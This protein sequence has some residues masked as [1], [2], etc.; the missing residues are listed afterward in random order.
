M[1]DQDQLITWRGC[2]FG[3]LLSAVAV[4]VAW[5]VLTKWIAHQQSATKPAAHVDQIVKACKLYAMDWDGHYP[6][7]DTAAAGGIWPLENGVEFQTSTE[8]FN[9]LIRELDIGTEEI[10]YTRSK[11]PS[12][13]A[14]NN[15][16]IL[17]ADENCFSLIS[18]LTDASPARWP[19]VANEMIDS[20]G[21]FGE[22]HPYLKNG[23]AIVGFCGGQVKIMKLTSKEPGAKL[24]ADL[25]PPGHKWLLP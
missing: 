1:S 5:T 14:P 6:K 25:L 9:E 7:F 18:G 15:D 2:V 21:S 11:N 24:S 12:K 19:L 13:N 10:F 16:G 8:A 3:V 17:A 22:Y 20:S 4:F 23:R